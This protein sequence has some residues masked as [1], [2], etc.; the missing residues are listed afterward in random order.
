MQSWF[1]H[2]RFS[3]AYS[4]YLHHPTAEHL[5]DQASL[6]IQ[7]QE[8][9]ERGQKEISMRVFTDENF[10]CPPPL[11]NGLRDLD[12]FLWSENQKP[13]TR[14]FFQ[15]KFFRFSILTHSKPKNWKPKMIKREKSSLRTWN[16]KFKHHFDYLHNSTR[17]L[18]LS[19][20]LLIIPNV[21]AQYNSRCW[22]ICR[23]WRSSRIFCVW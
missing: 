2:P 18:S 15:F 21:G 12:R 23:S 13:K 4:R 5:T 14:F 6:P 9:V 19:L 11:H 22:R 20:S 1:W 10:E 17:Q 7:V 3:Q 16:S 8:T